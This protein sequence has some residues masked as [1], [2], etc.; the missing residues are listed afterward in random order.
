MWAQHLPI[1][2]QR[3]NLGPEA[4]VFHVMKLNAQNIDV[5]WRHLLVR[6]RTLVQQRFRSQRVYRMYVLVHET[7]QELFTVYYVSGQND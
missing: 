7:N 6:S 5:A 1:S 4:T 2:A 3:N